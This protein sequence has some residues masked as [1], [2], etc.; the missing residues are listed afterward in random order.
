M[1]TI[2]R[3]K[4]SV[5]EGIFIDGKLISTRWTEF[6]SDSLFKS[7]IK[8]PSI[9]VEIFKDGAYQPTKKVRPQETV[10]EVSDDDKL[11]FVEHA[12]VAELKVYLVEKKGMNRKELNDLNK[13][14]LV[15]LVL[16]DN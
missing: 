7:C 11:E 14:D 15:N 10:V 13:P 6:V 1:E 12:T 3:A 2:F 9:S 5:E 16:A 8:N 4:T